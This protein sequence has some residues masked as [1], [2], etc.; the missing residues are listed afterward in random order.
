MTD[1]KGTLYEPAVVSLIRL[2]GAMH[3][4]RGALETH[5]IWETLIRK[6]VSGA[7]F[8]EARESAR[9]FIRPMLGPGEESLIGG[10]GAGPVAEKKA[11]PKVVQPSGEC[12]GR[13]GMHCNC[14]DEERARGQA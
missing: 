13:R 3:V 6:V 1:G 7:P 2:L 12:E 4:T 9:E 5:K 8:K 11:A 14:R 10:G